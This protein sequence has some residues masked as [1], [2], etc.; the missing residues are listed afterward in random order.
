MS[1]PEYVIPNTSI[2]FFHF[3]VCFLGCCE[4]DQ[5]IER[6]GTYEGLDRKFVTKGIRLG[7]IL[8]IISE[9]FFFISSF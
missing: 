8:F 1:Y 5:H 2:L 7:M 4:N 9:V 6:E 3:I